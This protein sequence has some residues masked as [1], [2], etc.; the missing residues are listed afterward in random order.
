M[1]RLFF[2]IVLLIGS[3]SAEIYAQEKPLTIDECVQIAL[4][5]NPDLIMKKFTL[6]M[7]GKDVTVAMS[8]FLPNISADLG[9][10][11]SVIGPSSAFRIDPRSGI[12]VPIQPNEIKSWA[13]STGFS[14]TQKIFNG[15]DIYNYSRSRSVKKSTQYDF[16]DTKQTIIY[17]V[18]ERYYNLLKAEKLLEVQKETL[19]SSEESYKRAETLFHVGK[20]P[21]SDVLKAKVQLE[22]NKLALIEAQNGLS[23]ARASLNHILGF[24][25]DK[26][27]EIV[28]N[29][30]IPEVE[31][32]YKD[33]VESAFRNHPGL[34]KRKFDVRASKAYI[35]MA[36]SQYLPSVSA[37]AGYSWRHKDFN[38]IKYMFDKDF[39]YYYGIQLSL[40]IFQG[41]SRVANLSK[42][43]LNYR[44]SV[45]AL[46]QTKR[47]VALEVK[48]AYF[49][50]QQ[51][52]KKIAVAKNAV[53]VAAEDLRLNKEKYKVGSGTMLDLI[54]AQVSYTKAKSDHIQ[55]LYDY[56]Y[57]VARLEKAMGK[58]EK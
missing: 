53:E 36:V 8:N 10:T 48:Q 24:D 22:N 55:A 11:H 41:F 9:Y 57:A 46:A 32:S 30:E 45:E 58:L 47:N 25:V 37:Y 38:R 29:L 3:F 1:K 14:A 42:A 54:N 51:A 43:E 28:D 50:V 56:K 13:S 31:I 49:E 33:A 44:S 20:V 34:K 18:K 23:I 21:K 15:Y 4:N 12:P 26:N 5:Q 27:I 40:P 7:A 2:I 17:A 6:K 16:Q 35:G 52:K 19:K 39:N